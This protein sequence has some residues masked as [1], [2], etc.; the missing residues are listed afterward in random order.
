MKQGFL[1]VTALYVLHA[2]VLG[3]VSAAD[4]GVGPPE[5]GP[6][7]VEQDER[8]NINQAHIGLAHPASVADVVPNPSIVTFNGIINLEKCVT[9]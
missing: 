4:G 9:G 2:L 7:S 3:Q 1:C 8:I 6:P 5:Q